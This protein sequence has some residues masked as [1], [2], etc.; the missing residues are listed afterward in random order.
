M[1]VKAEAE[2]CILY[3]SDLRELSDGD[4]YE[5][6]DELILLSLSTLSS[7]LSS[8]SSTTLLLSLK[9]E[10]LGLLVSLTSTCGSIFEGNGVVL[11]LSLVANLLNG[12]SASEPSSKRD[13]KQH[14]QRSLKRS[15]NRSILLVILLR[16]DASASLSSILLLSSTPSKLLSNIARNRLSRTKFKTTNRNGKKNKALYPTAL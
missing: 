2:I 8:N 5:L 12:D 4:Y 3:I 16:A 6:D 7:L 13:V 9:S 15:T 11:E 14:E 10:R 1:P